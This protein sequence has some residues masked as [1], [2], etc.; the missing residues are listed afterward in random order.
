MHHKPRLQWNDS[1]LGRSLVGARPAFFDLGSMC[2]VPVQLTELK[3]LMGMC[4]ELRTVAGFLV[5]PEEGRWA[6][7]GLG[8]VK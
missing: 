2:G 8:E 1:Y 6:L 3:A 7:P 4:G 5:Q